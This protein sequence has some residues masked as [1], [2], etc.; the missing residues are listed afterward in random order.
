[1]IPLP[2]SFRC[3]L[4]AKVRKP[5]GKSRTSVGQPVELNLSKTSSFGVVSAM[6][7]DAITSIVAVHHAEPANSKLLWDPATAKD[8]Y[9]KTAANTTQDKY[10]KLTMDNYNEVIL[11]VWENANK[12]RNGQATFAL[13]LFVYIDKSTE[14]A[15]IRRATAHN[16]ETS[17]ARVASYMQEQHME[18]GPLQ[19][20]YASVVTARLPAATPISIPNNATMQQLGHIDRMAAE[21]SE[22]RCREVSAQAETYRMVRIRLGTLSSP[23]VECFIAVEDLR[24]IL[25][26]PPFDLTP[27]FREPFVG[28][29]PIPSHNVDDI[30]YIDHE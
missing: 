16:I 12:V 24:L 26:I 4:V 14:N 2:D 27:I 20:N 7:V 28:D 10:T 1:M 13:L 17:A 9:V 23:P 11:Q 25:G 15:G 3:R 21:H 29:V 18:L 5:L 8:I 30:D 6:L 19:T 22:A